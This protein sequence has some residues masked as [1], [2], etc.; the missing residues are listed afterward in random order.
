MEKKKIIMLITAIVVV[1][2]AIGFG[3]FA[4][5]RPKQE[6][7]KDAIKFKE[8]YTEYNDKVNEYN[9]KGYVKVNLDDDNTFRYLTENEAVELLDK[10]T[11]VIYFGFPTCPWC[12]SLVSTLGKVAKEKN[13]T[14]YYLN[15]LDLRSSYKVTDGKAV[16]VKDGSAGYYQILEL[17]K[18]ELE[19]YLVTDKNGKSYKTNEKRLYAP[20]LVAVKDGKVTS[21]HVGTV[22][23]Q[24]SG[25]DP[26]NETQIAE[27]EGIIKKL[28]AS[29]NTEACTQDKC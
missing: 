17:L 12:R 10:G 21:I 5:T 19:D 15:V 1:A 11:G 2:L 22:E 29:K 13:E 4:F 3:I 9:G 18:D 27:I 20:T 28:I 23:S 24:E 8:E 7:N 16:K 26:L 14:I 6:L 25:N